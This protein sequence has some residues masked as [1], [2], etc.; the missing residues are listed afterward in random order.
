MQ[1]SALNFQTR[2]S[3]PIHF[4]LTDGSI[5]GILRVQGKVRQEHTA[6]ISQFLMLV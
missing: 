3:R 2:I 1:T 4:S 5:P 6:G